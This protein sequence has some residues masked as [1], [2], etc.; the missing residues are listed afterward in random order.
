MGRTVSDPCNR[1][2]SFRVSERELDRLHLWCDVTGMSLS[3]MMRT[4]LQE[5]DA[6]FRKHLIQKD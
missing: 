2:V 1:I 5:M 6:L 3:K 4:S